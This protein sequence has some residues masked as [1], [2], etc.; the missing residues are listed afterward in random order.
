MEAIRRSR[1]ELIMLVGATVVLGF[2]LGLLSN[3]AFDLIKAWSLSA[4]QMMS[5]A[6]EL[7]LVIAL[8]LWLA[9]RFYAH[10]ESQHVFVDIWLPYRLEP[11]GSFSIPIRRSYQVTVHA[12]RALRR[13]LKKEPARERE[14]GRAWRKAREEG[15]PLQDVLET[16]Y[17]ALVQCLALYVLHRYGEEALS[18]KARYGWWKVALKGQRLTIEDLPPPL[19][20]N[21][22]LLADQPPTWRL[23]WPEEVSWDIVPEPG[24]LFPRWELKHRWYGHVEIRWHPGL[25]GG[26]RGGQVWQILTERLPISEEE[27][28]EQ[29]FLV[30]ARMEATAHFRWAIWPGSEPFHEWATGLLAFLEEALDWDYFL[31]AQPGRLLADLAWKVGWMEKGTSLI[32]VLGEILERLERIEQAMAMLPSEEESNAPQAAR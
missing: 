31:A 24:N 13:R 18:P 26:R 20:E 1:Q 4:A 27:K 23:W 28:R 17:V 25:L 14:L 12:H 16:E 10:G 30:G 8:V 5:A 6:M 32:D 19:Q 2:L 7:L 3:T 21:P 29:I 11:D 22:Y 15:K 9:I